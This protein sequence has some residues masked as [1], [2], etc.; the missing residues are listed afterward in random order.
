MGVSGT[1]Y[2]ALEQAQFIALQIGALR[3]Y[4]HANMTALQLWEEVYPDSLLVALTD[5]FSTDAFFKVYHRDNN[6][7]V[8]SFL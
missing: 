2:R 5:T 6:P 4:E 3:G 1:S 7:H 8:H